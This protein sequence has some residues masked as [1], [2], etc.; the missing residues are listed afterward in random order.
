MVTYG[1]P[2]YLRSDNGPK[3]VAKNLRRWL[4]AV[5]VQDA[6]YRVRKSL[7][8]WILRVLQR[9]TPRRA[10]QRRNLYTLRATQVIIERWHHQYNTVGPHSALKYRPQAPQATLPATTPARLRLAA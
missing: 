2:A 6:V 7:G 3:M 9:K 10:A 5:G 1:V 4:A 8:E